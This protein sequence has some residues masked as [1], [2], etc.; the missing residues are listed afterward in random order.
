MYYTV[1]HAAI[2]VVELTVGDW[3][4][5]TGGSSQTPCIDLHNVREMEQWVF[6]PKPR[7]AFFQSRR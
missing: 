2:D 3:K 1:R 5:A 4:L 7:L 6:L